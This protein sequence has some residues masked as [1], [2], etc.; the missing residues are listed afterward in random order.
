MLSLKNRLKKKKEFERVF[1]GG[2]GLKEDFLVLKL[3]KN[4]LP[5]NR[6]GFIVGTKVSKR[7]TLRNKLKRR[8][9][10]LI[11]TRIEE[12]KTGYDII[13]IAQPGLE[14]RDF[15]ELEEITNK[16]FSRAK[17]IKNV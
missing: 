12:I 1:K 11:R 8:L 3:V 4:N 9:R 16:I 10:E 7:A 15:W 17:I 13:L 14:G 6:F 5:Q 2:K